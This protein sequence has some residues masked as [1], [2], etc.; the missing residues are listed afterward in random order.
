M[1]SCDMHPSALDDVGC[2]Y[3]THQSHNKTIQP[4]TYGIVN[5]RSQMKT[6]S[7]LIRKLTTVIGKT[8][9][10]NRGRMQV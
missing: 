2:D 8:I 3:A 7:G 4:E 5:S 6:D 10:V 9:A 1:R